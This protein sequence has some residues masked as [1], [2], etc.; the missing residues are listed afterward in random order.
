MWRECWK[1]KG[2]FFRGGR[3][4]G[5]TCDQC[6]FGKKL[7][8]SKEATTKLEYD[9][10]VVRS[11]RGA[12]IK[13]NRDTPTIIC[14]RCDEEVRVSAKNRIHCDRCLGLRPADSMKVKSCQACGKK[15][16]HNANTKWVYCDDTCKQMIREQVDC[17]FCGEIIG[18]ER[19]MS[20]NFCEGQGTNSCRGKWKS[21]LVHLISDRDGSGSRYT[22]EQRVKILKGLGARHEIVAEFK[23]GYTGGFTYTG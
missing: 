9:T 23:R 5:R 11:L 19:N 10:T 2:Q 12:P 20:A 8:A 16:W 15:D 14:K 1:C 18:P 3:K 22:P 7:Q 6:R 17:K 4:A 21:R 13:K